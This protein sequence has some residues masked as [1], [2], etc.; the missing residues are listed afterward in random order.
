MLRF[1]TVFM[2]LATCASAQSATLSGFV[3]DGS[4]GVPLAGVSVTLQDAEMVATTDA[5]GRYSVEVDAASKATSDVVTFSKD[6]YGSISR[7]VEST[8][9]TENV[10]LTLE[11]KVTY[12]CT[13]ADAKG[14][15]QIARTVYDPESKTSE[16]TYLTDTSPVEFQ[17]QLQSRRQQDDVL[18]SLC[19]GRTVLRNLALFRLCDECR[20]QRSARNHHWRG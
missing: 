7:N 5:A 9:E 4:A 2:V 16:I 20:R 3:M 1:L 18:P 10:V 13:T 12:V 17:A 14:R 6:G 8:S 15:W 19:S 11:G